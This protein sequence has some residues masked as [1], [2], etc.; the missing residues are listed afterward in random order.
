MSDG[1][2]SKP[3]LLVFGLGYSAEP[4]VEKVLAEGW[5]VS[6]TWRRPEVRD[7]LLSQGIRPVE[8]VESGQ[9]PSDVTHILVSIAPKADGE[10]V[11]G[12]FEVQL[13]QL[14]R[15]AWVGYLSSTN[16]YGDHDGAWVDE[17]SETNP[18]LD[19]GK[20]RLAAEQAWFK[21]GVD[22][23]ASVHV[24]R[25]AGIYGPGKNA[26][27]SVLDGRA[28]RVIKPGQVF[29]RIHR[30]DIAQAL[31]LA[32]NSD[33][34]NEVF[35]L[36]DDLPAPPQE[37]IEEACRLLGVDPPPEVLLEGADLSPMGRSFYAENKRVR[38]LKA[39]EMLGWRLAWPDYKMALPKL[40][41][42]EKAR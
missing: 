40:L 17:T 27:R 19:R 13:R 41:D 22:K 7:N 1:Q 16:V 28:R 3:H 26:V 5:Q 34:P 31:W 36:S 20:R 35:N 24:F 6:A 42:E 4:F 23:G 2:N 21:F 9:L 10:P 38:N 18:S 33:L 14:N 39:K 32:A 29:G 8:F 12:V 25:L 11:L 15:L 30:H 37:V